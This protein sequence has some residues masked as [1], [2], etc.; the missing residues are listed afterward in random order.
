ME[1][2]R[3]KTRL[4]KVYHIRLKNNPNINDGYVGVTRRSLSCRLSEHFC[5]KRLI[6]K[7]LR[8][9]NRDEIEII[10][11]IRLEKESALNLEYQLR[12]KQFIGWND[13]AGGNRATVK[14]PSCGKPLPK[15]R[16]GSYCEDCNNCKFHKGHIPHNYGQG[17]KYKLTDPQGN[18]YYPEVFTVFCRD[19]DLIPQ[20]LRKVSKGKRNHHKG[21]H[22]VRL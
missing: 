22:A 5:S 18:V 4:Y 1:K 15:R 2:F 12:P 13:R 20:N 7:I 17:E 21:W 3:S 10:E 16:G 19:Y 11:V 14:C 6:G 9:L 8:T